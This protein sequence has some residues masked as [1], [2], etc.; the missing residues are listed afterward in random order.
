MI[1]SLGVQGTQSELC[2]S[3]VPISL[4]AELLIFQYLF[5]SIQGK[6]PIAERNCRVKKRI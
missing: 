1:K 3:K 2:S 6:N 5:I 4:T